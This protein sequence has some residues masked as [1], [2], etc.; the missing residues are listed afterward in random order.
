MPKKSNEI[1]SATDLNTNLHCDAVGV[2]LSIAASLLAGQDDKKV[3][4]L[5]L[6]A[7][8]LD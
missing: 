2:F 6:Q 8:G 4:S 7:E 3:T 1:H 5:F